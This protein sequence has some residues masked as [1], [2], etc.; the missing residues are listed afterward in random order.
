MIPNFL[1]DLD[2]DVALSVYTP[3]VSQYIL[4]SNKSEHVVDLVGSGISCFVTPTCGLVEDLEGKYFEVIDQK[5]KDY[6]LI[7]IDHG[8]INTISRCDCAI[9]DKDDFCFVEFKANAVSLDPKQVNRNYRKAM[10]QLHNTIDVFCNS[11]F[12]IGKD[13][14]AQRAVEAHICFRHGYPRNTAS[15]M[16]YR[17]QFADNNHQCQLFFN[18]QK[19]LK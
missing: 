18:R 11:L 17:T 19:V 3:N 1:N 15:E 2:L 16:T 9:A 13:L 6:A 7:Q 10:R 12:A 5:R 8:I 14:F 4:Q